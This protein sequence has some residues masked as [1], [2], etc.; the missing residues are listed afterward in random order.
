MVLDKR[1]R[2]PLNSDFNLKISNH[3]KSE[4]NSDGKHHPPPQRP[5]KLKT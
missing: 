3:K 5:L 1:K 2:S 4:F